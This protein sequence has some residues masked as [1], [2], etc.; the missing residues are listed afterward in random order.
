M[1]KGG[2]TIGILANQIWSLGGDPNEPNINATF[3]QPFIN[4]TTKT[5]TTFGVDME[6]TY[7][8]VDDQWTVPFNLW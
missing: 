6:A 8:W 5:H 4:Y 2:W 7:D 3:L 1:Q